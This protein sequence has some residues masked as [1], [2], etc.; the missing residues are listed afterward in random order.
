MQSKKRL[1]AERPILAIASRGLDLTG[2]LALIYGL[3][4]SQWV[5][6]GAGAVVIALSYVAYCGL[7]GAVEGKDTTSLGTE[8]GGD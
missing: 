2:L 4:S 6:A 5:V 1:I 3:A 7:F 8:D